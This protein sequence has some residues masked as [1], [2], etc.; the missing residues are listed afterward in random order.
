M[1][2][3]YSI[4][5]QF[6][7]VARKKFG[8]VSDLHVIHHSILPVTSWLGLRWAPGG[9]GAFAPL[10]NTA[11]HIVMYT[12]YMVTKQFSPDSSAHA[13]LGI[14]H[15]FSKCQEYFDITSTMLKLKMEYCYEN[16]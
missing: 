4:F 16:T 7:F 5:L 8:Q 11:V 12:Y 2:S 14:R 15:V 10:L 9:H 3:A 13:S 1:I 6:A